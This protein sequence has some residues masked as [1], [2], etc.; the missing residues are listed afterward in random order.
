MTGLLLGTGLGAI[1]LGGVLSVS[2]RAFSAGLWLQA[3]GAGGVSIAGF[4]ALGSQA[5]LGD[6]FTSSFVPRFG[7]DG[8]SGLFLGILGLIAAPALVF[9]VRYLRPSPTGR[10]VGVLTALF[11]LALALVLCARDPLTFLAGW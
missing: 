10:A 4:W 11:V 8:L 6:T 7:V 3:I 2:G 9:S 1:A 5:A